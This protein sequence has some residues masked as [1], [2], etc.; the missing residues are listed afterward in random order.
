MLLGDSGFT[1][2]LQGL[3]RARTKT[4]VTIRDLP[5]ETPRGLYP[6]HAYFDTLAALLKLCET[7]LLQSY[8][9]HPLCHACH[10][11]ALPCLEYTQMTVKTSHT[12]LVTRL[13]LVSSSKHSAASRSGCS[14]K[15]STPA[16]RFNMA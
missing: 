6:I 15:L 8:L 12:S 11:V 5:D 10:V 9:S 16:R 13:C 3:E 4:I 14:T 1:Q 2:R 7:R